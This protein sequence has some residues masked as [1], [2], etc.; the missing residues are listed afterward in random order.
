M[1]TTLSAGIRYDLEIIPISS[2]R[3]NQPLL[4]ITPGTRLGVYDITAPLG[5]GPSTRPED[6]T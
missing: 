6:F 4:A 1:N 5:E 3:Y 2:S